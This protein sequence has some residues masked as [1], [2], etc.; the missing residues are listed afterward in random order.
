MLTRKTAA[1]N[2]AQT[3][4]LSAP[5]SPFPGGANELYG[6]QNPMLKYAAGTSVNRAALKTLD[7]FESAIS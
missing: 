1:I 5:D 4:N 3:G 2:T 6:R 7:G